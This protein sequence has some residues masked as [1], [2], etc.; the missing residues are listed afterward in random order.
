M[1]EVHVADLAVTDDTAMVSDTEE[2]LKQNL[3]VQYKAKR[4]LRTG[5]SLQIPIIGFAENG[6]IDAD[7]KGRL[8]GVGRL[9]NTMRSSLFSK[10]E[11][12]SQ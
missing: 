3:E 12:L 7:L 4:S 10:K 6:I 9:L 1:E 8:G 11:I 5:T 2:V